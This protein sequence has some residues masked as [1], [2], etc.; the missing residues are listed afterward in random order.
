MPKVY[1]V[2]LHNHNILTKCTFDTNMINKRIKD[3]RTMTKSIVI[4]N[5]TVQL[6]PSQLIQSGGE[7]MVVK[8][9]Q[10]AGKL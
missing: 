7:G 3:K 4:Q 10:T 8:V 9:G 5:K 1:Q 2:S 6:D